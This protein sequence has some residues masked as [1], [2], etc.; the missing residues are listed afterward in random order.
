MSHLSLSLPT[1]WNKSRS[2]DTQIAKEQL[3]HKRRKLK[4]YV[5]GRGFPSFTRQ[6]PD[7][8]GPQ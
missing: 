8:M 5:K 1:L 2:F 7:T 3:R 4:R 6:H